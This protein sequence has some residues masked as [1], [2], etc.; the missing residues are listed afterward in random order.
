[1]RKLTWFIVVTLVLS[2]VAVSPSSKVRAAE[3]FEDTQGHWAIEEINYLVEKEIVNGYPDGTFQPND[4]ITRAEAS[5]VII[6]ELGID[7][8][9]I[10]KDQSFPDVGEHWAKDYINAASS[11]GIIN[12]YKDGTFEPNAHLKRSELA[13]ILIRA[14]NLEGGETDG[15]KD[16]TVDHWAFPYVAALLNHNITT[17]YEDNTFRPS[18]EVT[19]AEFSTFLS[20]ILN[21]S[22]RVEENANGTGNEPEEEQPL[23]PSEVT[24]VPILMYHSLSKNESDWNSIVISPR[25]F[26]ED[27]LYVKAMGYHTI[28]SKELIAYKNGEKELPENPI[29]VTFD[30]GYRDNYQYAYPILKKLDMQAVISIIGWSVG[31]Y[32]SI[33]D[34]YEILPHFSWEE[35][36]EMVDSGHI[37]IQ[38]HSYNLHTPSDDNGYGQGVLPLEGETKAQ[39]AERFRQDTMKLHNQI[40]EHLGYEPKL[41]T[42]PYGSYNETTEKV[43]KE[44]GYEVSLTTSRGISNIDQG[45]FEL[46]RVGTPYYLDSPELMDQMLENMNRSQRVPFSEL[47]NSE[48]RIEELENY[49]GL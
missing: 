15:F 12:G 43:L 13:A 25:K 37:D 29:M 18:R 8:D 34:Q 48:D 17:G 3:Q 10:S 45:L 23:P 20:R 21:E 6:S 27:M 4:P 41:F 16:M 11:E 42:Y 26:Y 9:S 31:R 24:Q 22:F 35:A 19:R 39:H 28:T 5:K 44:L 33:G 38:N 7:L 40:K 30:D 47:A 32:T 49:L 36:K 1:M 14:Y 46:K 2:L